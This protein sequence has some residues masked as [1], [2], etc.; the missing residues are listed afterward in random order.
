MEKVINHLK[1]EC[2]RLED[3]ANDKETQIEIKEREIEALS[4]ERDNMRERIE[5][6][7]IAVQRL[8]NE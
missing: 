3:W 4:E 8:R 1:E 6:I 2:K 5:E 7:E